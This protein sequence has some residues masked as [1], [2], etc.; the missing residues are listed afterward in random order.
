MLSCSDNLYDQSHFCLVKCRKR[1]EYVGLVSDCNY[2]LGN[3]EP[4]TV[5]PW[6]SEHCTAGQETYYPAIIV[7]CVGRSKGVVVLY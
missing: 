3:L 2:R 7:R 4:S 6:M 1:S 5:A